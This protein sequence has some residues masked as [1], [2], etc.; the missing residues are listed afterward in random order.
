ME[1]GLLSRRAAGVCVNGLLSEPQPIPFGVPQ[2][3]VLGPL[4]FTIYINDLP[5]AVQGCSAELYADDTLIYFASKS[6]SEIQAQLTDGLTDGLSLLHAS[7]LILNLKDV[8]ANCFSASLLRTT[9]RANLHAT[10][11]IERARQV[12][13]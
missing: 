2:G 3:T 4:L 10:S 1:G 11:C 7:F 9:A 12:L 6:V 5:L 8:R 13:K